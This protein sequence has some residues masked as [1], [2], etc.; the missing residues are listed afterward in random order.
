MHFTKQRIAMIVLGLA[1]LGLAGCSTVKAWTAPT[2]VYTNAE[3]RLELLNSNGGS[4]FC[5]Q[6]KETRVC[7]VYSKNPDVFASAMAH[8][9]RPQSEVSKPDKPS[10]VEFKPEKGSSWTWAIQPDGSFTDDKG[11]VWK[12][13][14]FVQFG[15]THTD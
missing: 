7:G 4:R 1:S 5:L 8:F 2:W 13:V 12:L 6:K 9:N 3:G 15:K 11:E 10:P 14:E